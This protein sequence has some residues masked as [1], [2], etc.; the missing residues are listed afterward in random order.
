MKNEKGE[1]ERGGLT[2]T[3]FSA[4]NASTLTPETGGVI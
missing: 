2:R 1:V 4:L 3:M